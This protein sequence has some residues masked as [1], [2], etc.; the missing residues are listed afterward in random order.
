MKKYILCSLI[1]A[2]SVLAAD[3]PDPK[4]TP[5]VPDI[6]A[7]KDVICVK[8]YTQGLRSDG[9]KVRKVTNELKAR[10]FKIYGID[11]KSD[12]YEIDHLIPL[13]LGGTND[14]KNLWPQSYTSSPW[15]AHKKDNLENRMHTLVCKGQITLEQAQ[16]EISG[17]WV[18][19]YQRY[20]PEN[21]YNLPYAS[22]AIVM[23]Q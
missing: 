2:T 14:E 22:P 4:L 17:D 18:K 9:T 3:L 20:F 15:N 10:I 23:P 12:H 21:K 19:T 11:P 16:M 1:F 7:G 5:G 13:E 8:R 6:M